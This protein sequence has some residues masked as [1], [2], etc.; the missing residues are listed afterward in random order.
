MGHRGP[1]PQCL[2]CRGPSMCWTPA[3]IPAQSRV[4]CTIFVNIID[5]MVSAV[6]V[7]QVYSITFKFCLLKCNAR[8]LSPETL[9]FYL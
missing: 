1:D 6:V 5:F 9:H 7:E 8:N 3:I 4:R 2:T